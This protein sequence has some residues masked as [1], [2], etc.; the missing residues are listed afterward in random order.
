MNNVEY[1]LTKNNQPL[2]IEMFDGIISCMYAPITPM[3][4]EHDGNIYY[5][6]GKNSFLA[7][8][9]ENDLILTGDI[10]NGFYEKLKEYNIKM[11]ELKLNK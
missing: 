2:E 7:Y 1:L 11:N 5:F 8:K 6:S 9:R 3:R 10:P 4:R